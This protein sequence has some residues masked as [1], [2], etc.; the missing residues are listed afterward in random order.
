MNN[1]SAGFIGIGR[2]RMRVRFSIDRRI[3]GNTGI[4]EVF[5]TQ[6]IKQPE[7]P[8]FDIPMQQFTLLELCNND[9]DAWIEFHVL[10]K[11]NRVLN[12]V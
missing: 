5:T 10:N 6:Y 9:R 1:L 7:I 4:I 8:D 2:K 3:P 11:N 12:T